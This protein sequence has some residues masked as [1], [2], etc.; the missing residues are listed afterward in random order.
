MNLLHIKYAVEVAEAGSINQAAEKL[1]TGQPNL[2]RAIKELESSIGIT[3]FE[4]SAKGM[5]LTSDGEIFMN[6]AK[7]I[8]RQVDAI[9]EAFS[10]GIVN[11]RR[12]SLAAP[13]A[14]YIAEAFAR[15]SCALQ[16]ETDA[17]VYYSETNAYRV[18]KSIVQED[19]RLGIIRYA[20]EHDKY[21]KSLLEEKGLNYEMVAE[22]SYDLLM[23]AN[24]PLAA[25]KEIK[26]QDLTDCIEVTDADP[27][28]PAVSA[29]EA[30]KAS[31]AE[32]A[33]RRIF[34]YDRAVRYELLT[35]NPHTYMWSSAVPQAQLKRYGLVK[36]PCADI[37]KGY[38]DVLIYKKDYHF[39]QLD[40]LFIAELCKVKRTTFQA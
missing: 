28:V 7:N 26:A 35:E 23:S 20:N 32:T 5:R 36:K 12:F 39:S 16:R 3:I 27:F 22:F 40:T 4:R 30:K 34:V 33:R 29:A 11:C 18:M 2:S 15:F 21:Y 37:S 24:A 10:K 17:E 9:E 14:D 25:R 6:Y 13:R 19:Y 1:L 8:L 31:K 38:K